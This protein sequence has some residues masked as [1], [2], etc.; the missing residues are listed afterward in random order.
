[1]NLI[2]SYL[3]IKNPLIYNKKYYDNIDYNTDL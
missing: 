3:L 1:M 2:F